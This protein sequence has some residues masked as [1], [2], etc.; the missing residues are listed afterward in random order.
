MSYSP[1]S[2]TLW[3][4]I[5]FKAKICH[6]SIVYRNASYCTVPQRTVSSQ[7]VENQMGRNIP[8]QNKVRRMASNLHKYYSSVMH[9]G[10]ETRPSIC[11]VNTRCCQRCLTQPQKPNQSC[12]RLV[13]LHRNIALVMGPQRESQ[14]GFHLRTT[15]F[16][17]FLFVL[18]SVMPSI[19]RD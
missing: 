2:P 5:S 19:H 1:L 14:L 16:N 8:G 10:Q 11:K 7:K 12:R 4:T 9:L 13:H 15:F 18:H 6:F 3:N 17:L